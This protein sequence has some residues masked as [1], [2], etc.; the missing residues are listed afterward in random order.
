MPTKI[1]QS[2]PRMDRRKCLSNLATGLAASLGSAA[3]IGGQT[4]MPGF[5]S[6]AM[7]AE[8]EP[9]NPSAEATRFQIACMTLPYARFP[10]LRALQGIKNAGYEYVAW[11][12]THREHPN[13]K[14]VPMM[15]I[16]APPQ[17]AKDLAQRC[18]D[19]GLEPVMMFSTIYPEADNAVAALTSRIHQAAA[20]RIPQVLTFGHTEGGNREQWI[21]RFKQLAPIAGDHGVTIVVKQH[22]GSTGTGQACAEIIRQVD[23]PNIQVN[24]DAGNVLDYLNVD[25][26][27]DIQSCAEVVKSFCIKDHREWPKDEDCGPGF[28]LIDHYQLLH[29]VAFT[30]KDMPLC[31]ENIFAP[32]APHPEAESIDAL[33]RRARTYLQ[34]VISGLQSLPH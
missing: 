34:T 26:I 13:E 25:P 23:H 12:I 28:G 16:D 30:G 22:G 10:L 27:P 5:A 4:R 1:E 32:M 7:A 8:A 15:P 2:D 18:R 31:C 3:L 19:L 20:A 17:K 14:P 11:G 9:A 29:P 33:A 21:E 6:T 24:Y